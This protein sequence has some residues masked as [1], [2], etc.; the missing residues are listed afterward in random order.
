MIVALIVLGKESA[1]D[2]LV[3]LKYIKAFTQDD[4]YEKVDECQCL[5]QI[6]TAI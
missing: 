3:E 2:I 4:L 1:A 5:A 6:E